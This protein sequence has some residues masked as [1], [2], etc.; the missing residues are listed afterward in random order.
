MRPGRDEG[1]MREA[2][3]AAGQG[4]LLA[5]PGGTPPGTAAEPGLR[6][7]GLGR[8]RDGLAYVPANLDPARPA[9]LVLA[10]HGAG[11]RGPADGAGSSRRSPT[12]TG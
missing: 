7:L 1:A 12:R 2:D 4:R 6:P 8:G 11:R 5:R 9:P 3:E 10:L